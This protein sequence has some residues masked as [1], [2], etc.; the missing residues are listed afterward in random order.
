[1]GNFMYHYWGCTSI[2]CLVPLD[3]CVY[4]IFCAFGSY[5]GFKINSKHDYKLLK[6]L[7]NNFL[8][9]TKILMIRHI[10]PHVPLTM[11]SEYIFTIMRFNQGY[12]G[13][14][15]WPIN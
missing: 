13:I 14:R 2:Y 6:K 15:Q 4:P 12:E 11:K 1:M 8:S 3:P 10:S 9:L 7:F 5:F